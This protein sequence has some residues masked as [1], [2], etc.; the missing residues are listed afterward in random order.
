MS[1][2][3][4]EVGIMNATPDIFNAGTFTDLEGPLCSLMPF[5]NYKDSE[6][7]TYDRFKRSKIKLIIV[8][9]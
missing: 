6:L 1:G 7:E 3:G 4:I 5:S 9:V 8:A 2:L